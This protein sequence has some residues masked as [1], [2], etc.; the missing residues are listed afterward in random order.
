MW[1]RRFIDEFDVNLYHLYLDLNKDIS[2]YVVVAD[3]V[4]MVDF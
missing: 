2:N 3:W 4:A 1:I